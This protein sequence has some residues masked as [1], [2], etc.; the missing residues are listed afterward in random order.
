MCGRP[1]G[2]PWPSCIACLVC[3]ACFETHEQLPVGSTTSYVEETL[4]L[5]V[6]SKG[7]HTPKSKLEGLA[8]WVCLTVTPPAMQTGAC[9]CM[10]CMASTPREA[11]IGHMKTC[12]LGMGGA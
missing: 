10:E 11:L 9:A 12:V 8:A 5:G 4:A 6:P 3:S 7:A 1:W 2:P